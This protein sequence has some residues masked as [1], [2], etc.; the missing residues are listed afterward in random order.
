MVATKIAGAGSSLRGSAG[1]V[2]GA[3]SGIG[4]A[5]ALAMAAEGA[6]VAIADIDAA[7]GEATAS[8]I[9]AAGGEAIAIATDVRDE[10]KVE[11]MVE[12]ALRA[13]GRLDWACNNAATGETLA[14]LTKLSR[15]DWDGFVEVALV[16]V[17]LCMKH[18]IPAMIERGGG[19][20][21]N[22]GSMVGLNGQPLM[23]AYAAAKGGVIAL[24]K[25]AA[26]EFAP[27]NVRVN[28]VN[29]GMIA[30]PGN[31]EVAKL[32]PDFI[33]RGID[34]HALARM[35]KPEEVAATVAFL[36]SDG[37]GFITGQCINVEGG[38]SVKATTYP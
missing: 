31:E 19:A 7:S 27:M 12:A 32:L 13:F 16:G 34:A 37:A 8:A 10:A 17:W 29:P 9:A 5:T 3:G 25:S 28:V 14:P 26:A 15:K 23:S 1:I 11:A 22:I 2:T 6:R 36:C 35:G 4:R 21:V 30:T 38:V 24:S 18:E 33:Q 20:I